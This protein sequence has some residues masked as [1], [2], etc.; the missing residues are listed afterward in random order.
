[1]QIFIE[2][3]YGGTWQWKIGE[4]DSYRQRKIRIAALKF[5]EF[6]NRKFD[7]RKILFNTGFVERPRYAFI[8]CG[9]GWLPSFWISSRLKLSHKV[10]YSFSV[11]FVAALTLVPA[12]RS[13]ILEF[14]ICLGINFVQKS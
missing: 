3:L 10:T 2:R 13:A 14:A 8:I 7:K 6:Y 4:F 5:D 11:D 12:F 9:F 1:M